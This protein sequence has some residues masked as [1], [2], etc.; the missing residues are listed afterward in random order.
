MFAK[1]IFSTLF[2]LGFAQAKAEQGNQFM[3]A[4]LYADPEQTARSY[5]ASPFESAIPYVAE[6]S[7][8]LAKSNPEQPKIALQPISGVRAE[9]IEDAVVIT[10]A[11]LTN[12]YSIPGAISVLATPV[13]NVFVVGTIYGEYKKIIFGRSS[14][15]PKSEER[16]LTDRDMG[17]AIV[18]MAIVENIRILRGTTTTSRTAQLQLTQENGAVIAITIDLNAWNNE[19][20]GRPTSPRSA[21]QP[22]KRR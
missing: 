5:Q 15:P 14:F 2:L 11:D 3:C 16:T 18:A 6:I 20:K 10:T 21:M 19:A 1:L 9:I 4:Q 13:K 7:L 17:R 12:V 22:A 8:T